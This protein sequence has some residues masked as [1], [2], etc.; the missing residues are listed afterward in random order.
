MQ[1]NEFMNQEEQTIVLLHNDKIK[2]MEDYRILKETFDQNF[3]QY[4]TALSKKDEEITRL[5]EL[6]AFIAKGSFDASQVMAKEN[7][8]LRFENERLKLGD[9]TAEEFQNLCHNR[10]EKDGCTAKEFYDGCAEFQKSLFGKSDRDVLKSFLKNIADNY[11]C[12]NGAHGIHSPH[13]RSCEAKELLGL[14]NE[15]SDQA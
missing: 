12:D 10:H 14:P 7:S 1:M 2:L 9:F 6:N 5:T 11:D 3:Q 15:N 4:T 8:H 13:C